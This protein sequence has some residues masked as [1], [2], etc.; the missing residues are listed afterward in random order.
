M[1]KA[2]PNT[3]KKRM[4]LIMKLL[5]EQ[6]DQEHP[7]DTYEILD[8]L[9]SQG[10][11][12]NR[13][14]LKSDLDLLVD[15]DIDIVTIHSKPNK[16]YWGERTFEIPE[17]QLLIDAVLSSRFIT[18]KKSKAM[19]KKLSGLASDS[20]KK[21]LDRHMYA[22]GRVKQANENIFYMVNDINSA[23][24]QRK[25]ITFKYIEYTAEKKKVFRN[26]GEVYELSPYALYWNEDY[27]YVVGWSDKHDN[28]SVFRV[29]RMDDVEISDETAMKRPADFSIDDYSNRVFEM[30][31]GDSTTVKL[32]CR[33]DLMKY[34]I[35][36]FGMSVKTE[37]ATDDTFYVWTDVALSPT[38]YAWVFRF[39]GDI[40]IVEPK[41]A[42]DE[43]T[44]MAKG[45]IKKA[46][47]R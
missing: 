13:K 15:C 16:Y 44:E 25:K 37:I 11:S 27:Y 42:A 8:Y 20:Q 21:E 40:S 46:A 35:D 41:Q 45:L 28:V 1:S 7:L 29:D 24:S 23:I 31:D 6:T 12:T 47:A 43:I 10:V 22:T 34:I 30:F 38:F 36:R 33:N 26:D 4:M 9:E 39:G 32:E 19:A 3:M 17:L 18:K 14:T 2:K 5:R